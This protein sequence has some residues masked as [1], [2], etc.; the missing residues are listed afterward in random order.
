MTTL[1]RATYQDLTT[2]LFLFTKFIHVQMHIDPGYILFNYNI[3]NPRN[4]SPY[5]RQ[6]LKIFLFN[7]KTSIIISTYKAH[8]IVLAIKIN[9]WESI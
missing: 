5:H 9:Q 4:H 2:S 1:A 6:E 3:E 7:G 8:F